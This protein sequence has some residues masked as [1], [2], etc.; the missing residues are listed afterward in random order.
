MKLEVLN[1]YD[2][3]ND[4]DYSDVVNFMKKYQRNNPE[5]ESFNKIVDW[6]LI[7]ETE[8]MRSGQ[9]YFIY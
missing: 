5:D 7:K 1:D 6:T 9:L 8:R 3:L 2:I 4:Y